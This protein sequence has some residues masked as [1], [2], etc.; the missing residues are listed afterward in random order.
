M[1]NKKYKMYYD[2]KKRTSGGFF[3][4]IFLASIMITGLI[5]ILLSTLGVK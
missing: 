5:L 4:V 2:Y 3:D 1:T